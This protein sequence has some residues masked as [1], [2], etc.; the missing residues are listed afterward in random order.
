VAGDRCGSPAAWRAIAVGRT[1]GV[2]A[3]EFAQNCLDG[4]TPL[5]DARRERQEQMDSA[6]NDN[7]T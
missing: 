4:D 6:L 3:I 1:I 5:G 2:A 7:G